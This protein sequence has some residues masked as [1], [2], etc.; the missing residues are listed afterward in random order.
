[1]FVSSGIINVHVRDEAFFFLGIR[2]RETLGWAHFDIAG[3][4]DNSAMLLHISANAVSYLNKG[5]SGTKRI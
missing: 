4:M 2:G 1:M 5:M 3:V